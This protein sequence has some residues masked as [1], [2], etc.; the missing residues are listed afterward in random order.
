[1]ALRHQDSVFSFCDSINPLKEVSFA[2][3]IAKAPLL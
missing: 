2:R 1:M 3:P